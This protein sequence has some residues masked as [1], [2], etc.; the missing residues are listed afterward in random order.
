MLFLSIYID[1]D[2][3]KYQGPVFRK[4]TTCKLLNKIFTLCSG[5]SMQTKNNLC[6]V[7]DFTVCGKE[8]L[9]FSHEQN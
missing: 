1:I 2:R 5:E 4:V 8:I 3:D 7:L 6:T 9:D